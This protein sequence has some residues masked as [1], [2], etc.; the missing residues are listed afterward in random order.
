MQQPPLSLPPD[1]DTL[2][3]ASTGYK[4]HDLAPTFGG[5]SN[6][7]VRATIGGQHCVIKAT[8]LP[9][10]RVDIRREAALLPSL[11]GSSLPVPVLLAL[12][13]DATWTAAITVALPGENGLR[14]LADAPAALPDVFAALGVTLGRVHATPPPRL[15]DLLFAERCSIARVTLSNTSIPQSL[16]DALLA[17]LDHP[18]WQATPTGFVHG[19]VGLHNLLWDGAYLALLDWEWVGIGP[20]ALDLV[21]LRWTMRW[22]SLDHSLWRAFWDAYA[23]TS[24]TNTFPA[25]EAARALALGQIALILARTEGAAQA[26][27]LR[28]AQWTNDLVDKE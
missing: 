15:P 14:V 10:K 25:P 8:T 20:V 1:L 19:D 28:R 5:F 26:E 12:V 13:E 16:R 17:S 2:I 22:R 18:I 27:W 9:A 24:Q 21:W 6:L 7:T 23:A 11:T 3:T 4:A